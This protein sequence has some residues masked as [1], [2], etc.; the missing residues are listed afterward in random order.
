MYILQKLN[1]PADEGRSFHK[2]SPISETSKS[3]SHLQISPDISR[4]AICSKALGCSQTKSSRKGVGSRHVNPVV[5]DT[6]LNLPGL[7]RRPGHVRVMVSHAA[8]V[9]IVRIIYRQGI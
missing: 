1:V 4:S 5:P 3:P 8:Y 7:F 6:T 2:N 9:Q